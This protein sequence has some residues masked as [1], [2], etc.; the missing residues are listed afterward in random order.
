MFRKDT[1]KENA[2]RIPTSYEEEQR[3]VE[4]YIGNDYYRDMDIEEM[5]PYYPENTRLDGTSDDSGYSSSNQDQS[6][7]NHDRHSRSQHPY[8]DYDRYGDE[9]LHEEMEEDLP[10]YEETQY[11]VGDHGRQREHWV[12]NKAIQPLDPRLEYDYDTVYHSTVW[13]KTLYKR[14][15]TYRDMIDYQI[16]LITVPDKPTQDSTSS[17]TTRK[18]RTITDR[19]PLLREKF[20]LMA[21]RIQPFVQIGSGA[22][23]PDFP[24]SVLAFNLMTEAQLDAVAEFY[25]QIPPGGEHWLEYPCPVVWR[26]DMDVYEKRTLM[27]NFIGII[28]RETVLPAEVEMWLAELEEEIVKRAEANRREEEENEARRR[29]MYMF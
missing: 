17:S 20:T 6:E 7:N 10:A 28:P 16:S 1:I 19:D 29:K 24:S 13:Y 9:S 18:Y 8:D 3:E 25:H 12:E 22:V 2:A 21:R 15:P 27:G 26:R 11:L 14:F 23:C 4:A 5:D